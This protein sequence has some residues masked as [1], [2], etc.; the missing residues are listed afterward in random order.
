MILADW[1]L[2]QLSQLIHLS[3]DIIMLLEINAGICILIIINVYFQV[4]VQDGQLISASLI[5]LEMAKLPS[6]EIMLFYILRY[7]H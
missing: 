3:V 5:L 4:T 7:N 2:G 6:S 1:L